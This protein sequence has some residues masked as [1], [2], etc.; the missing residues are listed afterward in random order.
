LAGSLFVII[1]KVV[2][3]PLA[4]ANKVILARLLGPEFF[5][6]YILFLKITDV[7]SM[8]SQMGTSTVVLKLVGITAGARDWG[9]LKG[10]LRSIACLVAVGSLTITLIILLLNR[11]L[12]IGVFKSEELYS[13]MFF[14]LAVIPLQNTHVLT[15]EIFRGLQDL[16]AASLLPVLRYLAL[17]LL[18]ICL[19]FWFSPT[20]YNVFAVFSAS[21]FFAT[22]VGLFLLRSR[23]K[24]WLVKTE[25]VN[26][27]QILSESLPMMVTKGSLI[28]MSSTDVYVLG[29]C[30][31]PTEV[32]IYGVVNSL[33]ITTVFFLSVAEWVI[34]SMIAHYNAQKDIYSLKYLVRYAS[35]LGALFTIP[36]S[37]F[38]LVFGKQVLD[39]VFGAHYA[40]GYLALAFL[41]LAQLIRS[42]VGSCGYVLQM[43]GYHVTFMKI[44]L[45]S[46]I[47]NL[48]L[49]IILVNHFGKEGVAAATGF[50]LVMQ[51][52]LS[53][54]FLYK[55]T[56]ILTLA[57]LSITKEIW[58]SAQ[59]HVTSYIDFKKQRKKPPSN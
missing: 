37:I 21:I 47:T 34:P 24:N 28:I 43:T 49:N 3:I 59:K 23:A 1:G 35:T 18:L 7:A 54:I 57:S 22:A 19:W 31:D 33:A 39:V 52:T 29:A 8:F 38:L 42:L 26:S 30:T 11:P 16:K 13:I 6:V 12:S 53:L 45:L 56:G 46:G 20:I 9:K 15:S 51:T 50:S 5:G 2:L 41:T 36:I 44:C 14:C 40:S 25:S 10:A 55:K 48:I 32:G 4:L 17:L 27:I 58:L